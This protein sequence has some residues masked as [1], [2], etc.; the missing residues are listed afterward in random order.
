M[1]THSPPT[2]LRACARHWIFWI[3]FCQLRK[4][5]THRGPPWSQTPMQSDAWVLHSVH[6]ILRPSPTVWRPHKCLQINC[7]LV[8]NILFNFP[9]G[10]CIVFGFTSMLTFVCSV[11]C[12]AVISINRYVLI[13]HQP[14]FKTIYTAR[15]V[16]VM[17]AGKAT[18][19]ELPQDSVKAYMAMY[20]VKIARIIMRIM[21]NFENTCKF[22]PL[23]YETILYRILKPPACYGS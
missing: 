19:S 21:H 5:C 18:Q 15:N 8:S 12:L 9:P 2:L 3:T 7:L 4:L 1:G 14:H 10:A 23:N 6:F 11:M 20:S 17:I 16:A 13:C 22:I